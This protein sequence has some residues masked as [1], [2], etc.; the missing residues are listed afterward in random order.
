M[1][2]IRCGSKLQS[3]VVK[4]KIKK[5]SQNVSKYIEI[6]FDFVAFLLSLNASGKRHPF[7]CFVYHLLGCGVGIGWGVEGSLPTRSTSGMCRW[8][9]YTFQA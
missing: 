7:L 6:R 5:K 4:S 2:L 8:N 3:L 9:R 1:C